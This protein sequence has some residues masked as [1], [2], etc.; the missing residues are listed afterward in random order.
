MG[1]DYSR[2]QPTDSEEYSF[3]SY[4]HKDESVIKCIIERLSNQGHNLWWDAGLMPGAEWANK[5]A[6]KIQNCSYAIIFL[7]ENYV[8]SKFCLDELYYIRDCAAHQAIRPLFIQ[9]GDFDIPPNVTLRIHQYQIIKCSLKEIDKLIDKLHLILDKENRMQELSKY[10]AAYWANGAYYDACACYFAMLEI[11]E[12]AELPDIYLNLGNVYQT[13]GDYSHAIAYFEKG[14]QI[15]QQLNSLGVTLVYL[16]EHIGFSYASMNDIDKAVQYLDRAAVLA[17]TNQMSGKWEY[18]E[19]AITSIKK[20][21]SEKQLVPSFPNDELLKKVADF[22][23]ASSNLMKEILKEDVSPEAY[24]CIRTNLMRLMNYCRVVGGLDS[25]ITECNNALKVSDEEYSSRGNQGK[26]YSAAS[27]EVTA[28]RNF[29]GLEKPGAPDYDVF[30]SYK[31]E[32]QKLAERICDCIR[33][34]GKHVFLATE[35]LKKIGKSEYVEMIDDALN[36]SKH[37]IVVATNTDYLS[38]GWVKH[39]WQWFESRRRD[40]AKEGE[41]LLVFD[42]RICDK[43]DD[44][45]PTLMDKEI[46][47]TSCYED[48]IFNY[49]W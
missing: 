29:L 21:N 27:R 33:R 16:L 31:S 42:D 25:V 14:I 47:K 24:N 7:T 39:E 30:I 34:H 6:D 40:G 41:I 46:F 49:L 9:I 13:E 5:I 22:Q 4:A 2:I 44:F 37:L 35:E 23:R 17:E 20:K 38:T 8:K 36:H 10:A 15:C 19:S 45:P 11:A 28:F 48:R 26:D 3:L 18:Y 32:D 12:S 1:K 43:K